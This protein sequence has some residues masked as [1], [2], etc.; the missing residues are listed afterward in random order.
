MA[1]P[2]ADIL[3]LYV[4][5]LYLSSFVLKCPASHIRTQT[6]LQLQG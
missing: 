6:K 5:G 2:S 3:G 4:Q 1:V